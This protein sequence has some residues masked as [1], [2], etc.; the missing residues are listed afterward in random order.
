M[1]PDTPD[2]DSLPLFDS[3]VLLEMTGNDAALTLSILSDFLENFDIQLKAMADAAD[4]SQ[5]RALAHRMKGTANSVGARR[6]GALAARA[7]RETTPRPA[8]AEALATELAA[9][10]AHC[11]GLFVVMS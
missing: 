7:E 1:I 5:W 10:R 9:L 8:V 4:I 3:L 2:S 6:L 11:A